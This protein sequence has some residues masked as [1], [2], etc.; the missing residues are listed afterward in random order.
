MAQQAFDSGDA[1]NSLVSEK[2]L[3]VEVWVPDN[4][5]IAYAASYAKAS[6]LK[7]GQ[8]QSDDDVVNAYHAPYPD[9]IY[10]AGP[11]Q[12]TQLLP[13]RPDNP[14][15]PDNFEAWK[16]LRRFTGPTLKLF[17]AKDPVTGASG[18]RGLDEIPGAKGQPHTILEGGSH[19]LQEDVPDAYSEVLLKWLEATR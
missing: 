12:Y 2:L 3:D 19:F 7:R 17:G 6:A 8:I 14:Q 11:R 15:L 18:G 9:S 16:T 4:K 1:V 10:L 13:T 5:G